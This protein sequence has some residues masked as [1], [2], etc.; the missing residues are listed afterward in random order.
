MTITVQNDIEAATF[1]GI[2][3]VYTYDYNP[4]P[5]QFTGLTTQ[6]DLVPASTTDSLASTQITI[7]ASLTSYPAAAAGTHQLYVE[8]T[9]SISS[10]TAPTGYGPYFTQTVFSAAT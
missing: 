6:Y 9:C 2:C 8:I 7:S 1:L 3:G 4:K 5:S 10:L